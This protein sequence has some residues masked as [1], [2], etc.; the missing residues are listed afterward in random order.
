MKEFKN[1]KKIMALVALVIALPLMALAGDALLINGAGATFPYPLYSKWFF[2]YQK[3]HPDLKFNYQ[4]IGSGGGIKQI[5]A[6]TVDFGASDA[7]MSDFEETSLSQPILHIPT[8]LGAVVLAY[9]Q[10]AAGAGLKLS[11][12]VI[13]DI[14]LEH[15]TKWNDPRIV[16]L[17]PDKTLPDQPI[18]VAHRS[19]GSGTSYVFTDYLSKVSRE[20]KAK[21]GTGKSVSWPTGLGGKGNEGVT[22]VIQQTPGALGFIELGYAL[23]NK[24]SFASVQNKSG[25][26]ITPSIDSTSAAADGVKIPVDYRVSLTDA[27]GQNA[28]PISSLTYLLVYKKQQDAAKGKALVNFIKWALHEGQKTAPSLYYAPLPQSL[29]DRLD[30]TVEQIQTP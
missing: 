13:A 30:K 5:A 11:G 27:A 20:W 14:F 4:S 16:A 23:Q 29:V 15:I 18:V 10:P 1:I 9:N 19:D 24:I 25:N 6:K 2:D 7:P 3:S 28:Y 17:N 8:V 21:I 12:A 22:G 26:F